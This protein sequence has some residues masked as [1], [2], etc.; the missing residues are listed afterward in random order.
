ML[1]VSFI[2]AAY[3][4]NIPLAYSANVKNRFPYQ[5]VTDPAVFL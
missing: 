3:K 1:P 5:E 2:V 4:Y